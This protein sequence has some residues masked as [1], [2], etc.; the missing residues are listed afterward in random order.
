MFHVSQL[1]QC[2]RVPFEVVKIET[3]QLEPD[4]TYQEHPIKILD[5]KERDTRR[6]AIKS[7]KVQLSN[8]FEETRVENNLKRR[9]SSQSCITV[10][11]RSIACTQGRAFVNKS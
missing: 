9:L 10:L 5:Q 7:Y 2:L 6:R 11:A 3:I 8:Q 1:K 4:L